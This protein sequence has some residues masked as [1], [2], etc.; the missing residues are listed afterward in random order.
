MRLMIFRLGG[1]I[2]NELALARCWMAS[3]SRKRGDVGRRVAVENTKARKIEVLGSAV[4]SIRCLLGNLVPSWSTVVRKKNWFCSAEVQAN[5]KGLRTITKWE[6]SRRPQELHRLLQQT[7]MV[8][9][10][11]ADVMEELPEKRRQLTRIPNCLATC[12]LIGR[13]CN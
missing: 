7:I 3:P 5:G 13:P 8:R 11:K 10:I 12:L 2:F 9:R 4:D 6:G 1:N